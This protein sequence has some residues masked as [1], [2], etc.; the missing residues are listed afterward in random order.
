[1][2]VR[3]SHLASCSLFSAS[4]VVQGKTTARIHP[5]LLTDLVATESNPVDACGRNGAPL[6][7]CV[8]LALWLLL[9]APVDRTEQDNREIMQWSVEIPA[10]RVKQDLAERGN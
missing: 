1:M 7:A 10:V 6:A 8:T 2:A 4:T 5:P 3:E 9:L